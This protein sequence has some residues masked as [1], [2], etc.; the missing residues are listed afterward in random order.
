MMKKDT[1]SEK[2]VKRLKGQKVKRFCLFTFLP[3][4]LFT[5]LTVSS[6]IHGIE[7]PLE[8]LDVKT[9]KIA[10]VNMLKIFEAFP[11]TDKARVELNKSIEEKRY[12]IIEKKEEI[13]KL[14]GEVEFLKQK[15]AAVSPQKAT[16][17]AA[18]LP[19]H[20]TPELTTPIPATGVTPL[21][22]PEDSPL[23]FLFTP[24]AE[25]KKPF[26]TE[27]RIE[28]PV[29]VS[30]DAPAILPG[31]PSPVPQLKEKEALLY[32]KEAELDSF[33]GQAEEEIR[34]LEEGKTL[35]L[36]A[37]IYK[38]IEEVA[39]QDGYSVIVDKESILYGDGAVDITQDV[40]WKLSR[41]GKK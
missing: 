27:S 38:A 13:A 31:I 29:A 14:K 4:Y 2:M 39:A 37:K 26:P 24:P 16:T 35:T 12:S 41:P 22:L 30:T 20:A 8:R 33:V 18:N 19:P 32:E 3:L 10:Y 11:E 6:L 21:T 9:T 7:I 36:M 23:K 25:S 15:M 1:R 40:I 34:L 17:E 28:P 5:F